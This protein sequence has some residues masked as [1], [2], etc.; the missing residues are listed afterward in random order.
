MSLSLFLA[1]LQR[2]SVSMLIIKFMKNENLFSAL[3]ACANAIDLTKRKEPR[4]RGSKIPKK[5]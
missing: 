2:K 1:D 4:L 5:E 3:L